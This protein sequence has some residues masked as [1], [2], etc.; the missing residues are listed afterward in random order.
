[1]KGNAGLQKIRN[2]LHASWAFP[3]ASRFTSDDSRHSRGFTLLA[4]V[5]ILA[6]MT[7]LAAVL[8]P[9]LVA[10]NDRLSTD[11][12][13]HNL[14]GIAEGTE[15]YLRRNRAWAPNLAAHSPNYV[16]LDNVQLLQNPRGFPRY[17][18]AHPTTATFTNSGGLAQSDL[19]ALRFLLVSNLSQD[20]A[21]TI[22]NATE[23]ETWW[24]TDETVTPGLKIY[25]GNLASL[26]HQVSLTFLGPGGSYQID[27]STTDSSGGTLT[28]YSKYHVTGTVVSLDEDTPYGTPEI[29]FALT[30]NVA[31]QFDPCRSTGDRWVIAP[32][33]A[34]ICNALWITTV[35]AASGIPVLST[36]QPLEGIAFRDPNLS[37][38]PSDPIGTTSG[39]YA[40]VFNIGNFTGSSTS[41]DA[42][43]Y[44]TTNMTI[45][46]VL[47]VDVAVGDL[48]L[49]VSSNSVTLTSTNSLT[50]G[51]NEVFIFRPNQLGNYTS[52]TFI[53]FMNTTDNVTAFSLVEANTVVGGSTLQA[54]TFLYTRDNDPDIRLYTPLSVGTLTLGSS[55][56][57]LRGSQV[58]VDTGIGGIELIETA[59][60]TGGVSLQSGQILLT[61]TGNENLGNNNLSVQKQDIFIFGVTNSGLD[62]GADRADGTLFFDGSDVALDTDNEDING[63]TIWVKP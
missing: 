63:L 25:R 26:F 23:F 45:G 48:L 38:E 53:R 2:A 59:L 43:H 62:S 30:A 50:V 46:S 11:Q 21:P 8:A 27:G 15:L 44:V 37:Y 32:M 6:V 34:A 16:S 41:V 10:I 47:T 13:L 58:G 54:G 9:N 22:T 39:S 61:A 1:V 35:G 33:P 20:A 51:R 52:G 24:A 57:F 4:M 3:Y 56:R 29:Q 12:E 36:W 60:T 17:Y 14:R 18:A 49:S 5:G 42:I 31:Y 55:I 7:I 19:V 40:A 28:D